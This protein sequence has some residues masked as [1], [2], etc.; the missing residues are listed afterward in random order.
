MPETQRRPTLRSYTSGNSYFYFAVFLGAVILITS[1]TLGSYK[2]SLVDQIDVIDG[3]LRTQEQ[4]RNKDQ[5]KELTAAAKQS[6]MMR[7]LLAG[8]IY[9]SQALESIGK[10]MQSSVRLL[11]IEGDVDGGIV[12][13]TATAGSY[14]AVAQQIASFI[15]ATGV[16]DITVGGIEAVPDGSVEFSGELMIDTKT[17]LMKSTPL[18]SPKSTPKP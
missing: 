3:K 14:S 18:P 13:F 12:A 10:M 6:K 1:A 15:A 7:Q 16:K 8:K 9:W 11:S 5:E 2:R 17:L 4:A